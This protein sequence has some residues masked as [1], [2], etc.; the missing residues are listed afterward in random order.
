[1]SSVRVR[2]TLRVVASETDPRTSVWCLRFIEFFDDDAVE[3]T[4]EFPP[5]YAAIS[6]HDKLFAL[7]AAVTACKKMPKRHHQRQFRITLPPEVAA[8]Y[9]DSE[10][11]PIFHGDPLDFYVEP[12]PPAS[13]AHA[14]QPAQAP[15]ADPS[16]VSAAPSQ[17]SLSS[18]IKDAVISRFNPKSSNAASW[19]D[20]FEREC[21]RVGVQEERFW[22]ALRLFLDGAAEHWYSSLRNT[23][24]NTTWN[25][26]RNSFLKNFSKKGWNVA[27]SAF[28]YRYITGSYVDYVHAKINLLTSYNPKMHVLDIMSHLVLGLP[29]VIQDRINPSE[30]DELDDLVAI[31]SSFEKPY[32]RKP[33]GSRSPSSD[34]APSS[35]SS[36]FASLRPRTL[37]P[38]CKS[39][40]FERFHRENDCFTKFKDNRDKGNVKTSSS[41]SKLPAI[42]SFD[43]SSLN[44]VISNVQKNE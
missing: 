30:V 26:W 38:Y 36:A 18:I 32:S 44:E 42:H 2:F 12:S 37:C 41:S 40:G 24:K 5:E 14:I 4:Y 43:T 23:S 9:A 20:I 13:S 7:P 6:H 35:G 10:G 22:E 19:L 28:A 39:K 8:I 15:I 31:I 27:A 33:T 16:V 29:A 11:N 21:V 17:R 3:G 25:F 1:M 34:A